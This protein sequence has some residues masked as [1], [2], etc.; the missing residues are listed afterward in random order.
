MKFKIFV[1]LAFMVISIIIPLTAVS[2]NGNCFEVFEITNTNKDL[3]QTPSSSS[4][5]EKK[6]EV[7]PVTITNES[8]SQSNSQKSEASEKSQQSDESQEELP[9]YLEGVYNTD[10]FEI[11]DLTTGKIKKVNVRDYVIGA[12]A[13]EMPPNF[14]SEALKAQ[15]VASHSL[16]LRNRL[17]H[18]Q[19]PVEELK[20]ADFSA[21]PS[22][23][24]GYVT[25]DEAKKM[26]GD[27]FDIYWNKIV[28]ACDEVMNE[29][30]VYK[31]KPILAA[32]H[33]M[34]SGFTEAA[35]NVWI[36]SAD[37]LVPVESKGDILSPNY[38]SELK[39]SAQE[40]SKLFKKEYP[41]IIL[42]EDINNWI[43]INERSQGGYVLFAD[44][45]NTTI[46]GKDIR[47]VL[48]LRSANFEISVN[49][50]NIFTFKTLGYGHGVGLSQYG[51][52]Y[53]ARQGN[54]Y[55]EILSHYYVGAKL[56]KTK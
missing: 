20:G 8:S 10:F 32:Y 31:Q 14:N 34:S 28:T 55:S 33:S 51:A 13:A 38:E 30:L 53:M 29:V 43:V 41:E 42:G 16:A 2:R 26:Y 56:V 9:S 48:G 40:L 12:V 18:M 47:R 44:V 35:E 27:K 6:A 22:N 54:T 45:G 23:R 25:E 21:D 1:L 49:D 11:L 4:K 5:E 24:H 39:I 15:A 46:T 36:G 17:D 7:K 52:D 50:D 19:K 3:I 37:Y